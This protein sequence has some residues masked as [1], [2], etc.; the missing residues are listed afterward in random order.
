MRSNTDD[1]PKPGWAT[2][3]GHSVLR[4]LGLS[5]S[6]S[7]RE[8][9]RECIYRYGWGFDERD[10]ERLR[11]CFTSDAVWIGNIMGIDT[12]GPYAGRDEIMAFLSD[13]WTVQTDQR[14]HFFT[15][16]IFDDVAATRASAQAYFLLTA[17]S[18][19]TMTPMTT[20]PY[21][22]EM[23][24]HDGAWRIQRLLAGFDAPF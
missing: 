10:V 4:A 3:V 9:I 8:E 23:M 16:I 5:A 18:S 1:A 2:R 17:A 21:R 15:N 14:R 12:V 13:F 7:D 19:A 11:D 20:G 24:K 22:F 6:G